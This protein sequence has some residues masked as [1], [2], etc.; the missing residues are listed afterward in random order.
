[1]FGLLQRLD[2]F[3]FFSTSNLEVLGRVLVEAGHA[4]VPILASEH[5]AAPELLSPTSLLDVSY[6]FDE[7]FLSH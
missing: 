2:Y 5:A 1:M 4:R 6:R 7:P 3:L